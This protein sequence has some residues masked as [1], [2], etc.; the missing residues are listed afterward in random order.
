[1]FTDSAPFGREAGKPDFC[2]ALLG[3][4][5]SWGRAFPGHLAAT[6]GKRKATRQGLFPRTPF[7]GSG[8]E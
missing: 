7:R 4:A 8:V 6:I 2:F 1:V 5:N 3:G